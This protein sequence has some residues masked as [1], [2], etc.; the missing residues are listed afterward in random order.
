[1][2]ISKISLYIMRE[3]ERERVSLMEGTSE[4]TKVEKIQ[5]LSHIYYII[6]SYS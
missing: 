2:L 3:R 5:Q 1:M 4:R 6:N